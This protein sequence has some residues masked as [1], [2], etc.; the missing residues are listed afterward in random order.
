MIPKKLHFIWIGDESRR[1][2]KFINTW[3]EKHPDWI[4][5]IWGNDEFNKINWVN[6][7]HMMEFV[8]INICGAVDMMRY[9]ILF[10]EGGIALDAD[11]ICIRKIDESILDC[12]V[13]S[14]WENE[15]VR[16]GL[17]ANGT[18]GAVKNN[19]FI[20]KMILNIRGAKSVTHAH[21]WKTVG[22]L[23]LTEMYR[24]YAYFKMVVLPS[25][26][27]TPIHCSGIAYNG[28]GKIYAH[29]LWGS[30]LGVSE[31]MHKMF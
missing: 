10:N 29:Q 23:F 1:P 22:P 24:K 5:K 19:P 18:M 21:P 9:E 26:Y 12:E 28:A 7:R 17:I 16:P 2:D 13:F 31:K 15:I 8:P 14:A 27:F 20:A 30:T 25:Y 3:R 6:K 11:S 4:I